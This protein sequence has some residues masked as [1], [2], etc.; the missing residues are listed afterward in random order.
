M[1]SLVFFEIAALEGTWDRFP[2][3]N[4]EIGIQSAAKTKQGEGE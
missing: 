4:F 3:E 1:H 2:A